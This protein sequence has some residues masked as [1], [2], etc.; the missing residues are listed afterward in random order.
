MR[1]FLSLDKNPSPCDQCPTSCS[2]LGQKVPV[3]TQ[4]VLLARAGKEQCEPSRALQAGFPFFLLSLKAMLWQDG[5]FIITGFIGKKAVGGA[6]W[7]LPHEAGTP[8]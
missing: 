2:A 1:T 4:T 3:D 5:P 6:V 8:H 7:A